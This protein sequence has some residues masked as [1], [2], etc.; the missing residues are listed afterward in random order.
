MK[1]SLDDEDEGIALIRCANIFIY[2]N[3]IEQRHM[4]AVFKDIVELFSKLNRK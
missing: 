1:N 3:S 2:D 4:R